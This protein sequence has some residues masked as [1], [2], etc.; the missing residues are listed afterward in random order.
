MI[1]KILW[2]LVQLVEDHYQKL[3]VNTDDNRQDDQISTQ[4]SFGETDSSQDAV[5]LAE[6]RVLDKSLP[7]K[8]QD[9][10]RLTYN[11]SGG[12]QNQLIQ[13]SAAW[14]QESNGTVSKEAT[15]DVESSSIW[16]EDNS[17]DQDLASEDNQEQEALRHEAIDV[18]HEREDGTI[19]LSS[20]RLEPIGTG[21]HQAKSKDQDRSDEHHDDDNDEDEDGDEHHICNKAEDT[22]TVHNPTNDDPEHEIGREESEKQTK[23]SHS[24]TAISEASKAGNGPLSWLKRWTW[25]GDAW[26]NRTSF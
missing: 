26:D 23:P 19:E 24:E 22:D 1:Q 12:P 3:A 11:E 21:A 13:D 9:E 4:N 20:S 16:S 6:S 10:N 2:L 5:L 15:M 17:S 8:L 14:Q 18:D 7:D 25:S